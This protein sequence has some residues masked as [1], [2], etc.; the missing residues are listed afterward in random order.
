MKAKA[1]PAK[2][3]KVQV[4]KVAIKPVVVPKAQ[5]TKPAVTKKA[6]PKKEAKPTTVEFKKAE[7]SEQF[8]EAHGDQFIVTEKSPDGGVWKTSIEDTNPQEGDE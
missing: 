6:A 5:P 8:V 7:D 3:A 1:T 4:P 2:T